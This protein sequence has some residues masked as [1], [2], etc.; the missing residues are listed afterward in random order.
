[1]VHIPRS[2][3]AP[4]SRGRRIILLL[5][6]RPPDLGS[7]AL[8][9]HIIDKLGDE[10]VMGVI[11]PDTGNTESAHIVTTEWMDGTA[12]TTCIITNNEDLQ[13]ETV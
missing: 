6:V 3:V 12:A 8:F 13:A 7:G 4:H 1:M 10:F 5:C 9:E 2:L 11:I